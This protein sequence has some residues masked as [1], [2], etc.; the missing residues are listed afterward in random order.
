MKPERY[1]K[2]R[3]TKMGRK[4]VNGL[5]TTEMVVSINPT[6][7]TVI[8]ECC[9]DSSMIISKFP[10]LSVVSNTTPIPTMAF[11]IAPLSPITFPFK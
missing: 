11:L 1:V 8:G 4:M 3:T 2:K 6:A 10:S 7:L 5:T 9:I